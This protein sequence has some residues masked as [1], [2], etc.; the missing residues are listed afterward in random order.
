ME[1]ENKK[2]II[3]LY[4]THPVANSEDGSEENKK[5]ALEMAKEW[6]EEHKL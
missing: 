3:P 2:I 5:D 6:V 1:K 4:E